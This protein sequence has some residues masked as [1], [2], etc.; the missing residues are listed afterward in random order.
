MCHIRTLLLEQRKL[1]TVITELSCYL[2]ITDKCQLLVGRMTLQRFKLRNNAE[3]FVISSRIC[4]N[5]IYQLV[6]KNSVT[7]TCIHNL[8][9]PLL[10]AVKFFRVF[11]DELM[12]LDECEIVVS[13]FYQTVDFLQRHDI[14]R[15][16]RKDGRNGKEKKY[17]CRRKPEC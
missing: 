14:A 11:Y 4:L 1:R 6:C 8:L 17:Q 15:V 16:L 3:H 12:K 10:C 5:D 7:V 13:V 2:C 9:Y